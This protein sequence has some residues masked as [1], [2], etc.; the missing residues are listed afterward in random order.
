MTKFGNVLKY[1]KLEAKIYHY[2]ITRKYRE[3]T[4][5]LKEDLKETLVKILPK[6]DSASQQLPN[7]LPQLVL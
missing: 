2:P 5:L 7:I 4:L 6:I 3:T 1:E